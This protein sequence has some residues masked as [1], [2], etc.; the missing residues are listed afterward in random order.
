M[1]ANVRIALAVFFGVWIPALVVMGVRWG[2][3]LRI[4]AERGAD[5]GPLVDGVIQF[6]FIT[7]VPAMVVGLLTLALLAWRDEVRANKVSTPFQT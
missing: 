7:L 6:A 2:R 5:V 1:R 4:G 3:P